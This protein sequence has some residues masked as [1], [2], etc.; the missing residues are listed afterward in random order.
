MTHPACRT[1]GGE[2]C[3]TV[4]PVSA[5]HDRNVRAAAKRIALDRFKSAPSDHRRRARGR[6]APICGTSGRGLAPGRPEGRMSRP[7][8]RVLSRHPRVPVA[9]IH[10]G[11]TLPHASSGL[12]ESSGEQPSNASCL[13]LL[14][15][16]FAEPHRSPGALVVSYTAV[17][18]LP[19]AR[20]EA[21]PDGG[22]FSVA[23]SRGSPRVGV[24]HHPALRS[25]DVPRR[26]LPRRGRLADS[27]AVPAY[28]G[29]RRGRALTGRSASRRRPPH[30]RRPPTTARCSPTP[31]PP[32]PTPTPTTTPRA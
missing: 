1:G 24:T 12:P 20:A 3:S 6:R 8:R 29:S 25:P 4:T 17:S 7:V 10:L 5:H 28:R 15:V 26:G 19:P 21:R 32:G 27:S 30:A 31:A 18:P 13:A 2:S 11:R 22:L 16:G 9:A 14:Q 23:L